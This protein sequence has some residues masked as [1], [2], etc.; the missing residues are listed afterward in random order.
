M[1][2]NVTEHRGTPSVID[3][4]F[5][6]WY[7]TDLKGKPCEDHCILQHSNRICVITLAESHPIIQKEKKIQSVNYQISAGCSRLQNKVSGKSKRGGQFLTELAPLCRITCTDGEEYTIFSCIRGRLLEVNED[8]LTR[9]SLL[10]E[11]PSTDGYIAVILPKFEESK[12][13]TDGLLSRA[14]YEEVV[15]KR[16]AVKPEPC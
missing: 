15:S 9:P 14:E 16:T 7:K 12:S 10:L 11:K 4:Y 5:T 6:R 2:G 3:R 1:E 13:V 8:I